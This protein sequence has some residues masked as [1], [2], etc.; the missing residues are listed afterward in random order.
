MRM[1]TP[2]DAKQRATSTYNPA[3]D[4]CNHLVNTFWERYGQRTVSRLQPKAGARILDVCCGRGASAI[5]AAKAVGSNGFILGVDL[6]EKQ[7]EFAKTR[8]RDLGLENIEFQVADMPELNWR[9][10]RSTW[11]SVSSASF[12]ATRS[13][14]DGSRFI[15]QSIG[16]AACGK[17]WNRRAVDRIDYD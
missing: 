11:S 12:A 5:P 7:I 10:P 9:R 17:V 8:A 4:F 1:A 16:H 2:V 6:A 15:D 3:A 13:I 14:P